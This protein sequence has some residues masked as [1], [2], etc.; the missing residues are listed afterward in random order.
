MSEEDAAAEF[1]AASR[2]LELLEEH[3]ARENMLR[4]MMVSD[5]GNSRECVVKTFELNGVGDVELS[6]RNN[7]HVFELLLGR[8]LL[9]FLTTIR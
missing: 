4:E 9:M 6:K 1:V 8:F 2:N 3:R 5:F 7:H